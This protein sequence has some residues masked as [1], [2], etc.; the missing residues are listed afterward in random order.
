MPLH[1]DWTHDSISLVGGFKHWH[2]VHQEGG[3]HSV[4]SWSSSISSST[5][6]IHHPTEFPPTVGNSIAPFTSDTWGSPIKQCASHLPIANLL[7]RGARLRNGETCNMELRGANPR[8]HEW[9]PQL[10]FYHILASKHSITN[11]KLPRD[12][13]NRKVNLN[14][15]TVSYNFYKLNTQS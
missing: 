2:L 14:A 7:E 3:A 11:G 4:I 6:I 15:T 10:N 5:W 8:S 12:R 1:H 9:G 13:I